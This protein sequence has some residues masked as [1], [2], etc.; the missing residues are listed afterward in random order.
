LLCQDDGIREA[1]KS[2]QTP[3]AA[4]RVAVPQA[5]NEAPADKVAAFVP[6]QP[7]QN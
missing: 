3:C 2:A 4:D 1:M 7:V 5:S 6:M